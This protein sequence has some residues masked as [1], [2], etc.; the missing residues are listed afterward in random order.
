RRCESQGGERAIMARLLFMTRRR[1]NGRSLLLSLSTGAMLVLAAMNPATLAAATPTAQVKDV[2]RKDT[3]MLSAF[4]NTTEIQDPTNMN[5]YSL[6]GLGRVRDAL[7]KTIF[8]FLYIYNHN[9]GQE[10]PW[11]A[12]SY[13]VAPDAQSID[14]TLRNG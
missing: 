8:E 12:E 5:P 14:V 2:P 1:V 3:L 9:N 4:G 7:N 11:L 13:T 10:I 6:G